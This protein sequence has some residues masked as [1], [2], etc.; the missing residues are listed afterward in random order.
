MAIGV[1]TGATDRIEFNAHRSDLVWQLHIFGLVGK[2]HRF[3]LTDE[4][5]R[6]DV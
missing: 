6:F 2:V 5:Y 4:L 3:H 1:P